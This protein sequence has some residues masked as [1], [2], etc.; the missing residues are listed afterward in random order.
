MMMVVTQGIDLPSIRAA[1]FLVAS[2]GWGWFMAKRRISDSDLPSKP[3]RP[4]QF[5]WM[6]FLVVVTIALS[7]LPIPLSS[8]Y[9]LFNIILAISLATPGVGRGI[10]AKWDDWLLTILATVALVSGVWLAN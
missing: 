4:H 8:E 7:V 10:G 5:W 1:I 3:A 6:V 9:L 2:A